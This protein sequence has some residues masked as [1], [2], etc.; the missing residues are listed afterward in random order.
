LR[1]LEALTPEVVVP[2]AVANE[3]LL[4]DPRDPARLA[5]EAGFGTRLAVG[6]IPVAVIE[7]SLGS[8]ET[9]VIAA[10][11]ER[12]GAIA[13]LDDAEA[14]AC[15]RSLGVPLVGTLG[16]VARCRTRNLIPSVGAVFTELRAAG[17]FLEDGLVRSVLRALGE[18]HDA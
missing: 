9:S 3:V 11:L 5:I 14:R 8:G 17:L 2:V 13:V 16:V 6:E 18:D 15:A 1:L 12:P 10:C 4:G 7:W